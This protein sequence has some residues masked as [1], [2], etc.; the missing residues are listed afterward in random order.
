MLGD[1]LAVAHA[2]KSLARVDILVNNAGVHFGPDP[3][4]Q[5]ESEVTERIIRTNMLAH[6][7]TLKAFLPGMVERDKGIIIN[8]ASAAGLVGVAGY[9]DYCAS[10]FAVR[11]LNEA[12]R[13]QLQKLGSKVQCTL[14]APSFVDTGL[15]EGVDPGFLGRLLMPLLTTESVS[16]AIVDAGRYGHAELQL[17]WIT[18]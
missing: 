14:A 10:K 18:R 6:F 5:R 3:L 12:L 17:P 7:W 8:V 2:A 1:A 13:M 11:G 16:K 9:A 4:L 15:F